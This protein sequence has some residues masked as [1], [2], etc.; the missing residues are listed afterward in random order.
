M[1]AELFKKLPGWLRE[2]KIVPNN[3][4]VYDNGLDDVEK[5]FQEYRDGKISA[6]KIVYKIKEINM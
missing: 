3:T 2:K 1:S 4:K 6:Y 5:G